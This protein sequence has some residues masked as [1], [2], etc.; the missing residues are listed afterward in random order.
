M[1]TDEERYAGP[2]FVDR[3]ASEGDRIDGEWRQIVDNCR[4]L[5]LQPLPAGLRLGARNATA[6]ANNIRDKI[7]NYLY[8]E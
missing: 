1:D 7:K 2:N 5:V 4:R 3:F 6:E 8:C